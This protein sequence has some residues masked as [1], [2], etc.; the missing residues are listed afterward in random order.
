[1]C[2]KYVKKDTENTKKPTLKHV[3]DKKV[4]VLSE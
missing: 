4:L 3:D 1:M 2:Q